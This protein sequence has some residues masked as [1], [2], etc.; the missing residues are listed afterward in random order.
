[1]FQ[2]EDGDPSQE[3]E[4]LSPAM[5]QAIA[6]VRAN[7]SDAGAWDKLDDVNAEEQRPEAVAWLFLQLLAGPDV[8]ATHAEAIGKRAI[9]FF[10]EWFEDPTAI[11]PTLTRVMELAPNADWAFHRLT[12]AYTHAKRWD[13]LL[14][15]YDHALVKASTPARRGELLDEAAQLA[16]DFAGDSDRATQYYEQLILLRP[17]DSQLAAALER[18]LERQSRYAELIALWT[19]RL[20]VLSPDEAR[21]T[22]LRMAGCFLEQLNQPEECLSVL[23]TTLVDAPTDPAACAMV[24]RVL[25]TASIKI[26]VRRQARSILLKSY[27]AE[28]HPDQRADVLTR[29]KSFIDDGEKSDALRELS[30]L[31]EQ[32]GRT[33]EAIDCC[34][35]LVVFDPEDDSAR[36]RL[37]TLTSSVSVESIYARTLSEAAMVLDDKSPLRAGALRTEAASVFA[38][39]LND[40]ESAAPLFEQVLASTNAS[41]EDQRLA[42]R[43]LDE[44][45]S[46][47]EFREPLLGTLERR[48][49]LESDVVEKCQVLER[50]ARLAQELNAVDRALAAWESIL[51]IDPKHA[52]GLD[53]TVALL[54][55][56]G[57]WLELVHALR[58]RA[59]ASADAQAVRADLVHAAQT[60]SHELEAHS[61]AVALW[62]EIG[63]RFG[64][65][66]Q[67]VD[68]LAALHAKLA[69]W[70]A[71]AQLLTS[72]LDD[73]TVT[74][75][76]AALNTQLGDVL[77]VHLKQPQQALSRFAA[78][79][80]MMPRHQD[81]IARLQE[82][83]EV[84]STASGAVD[85]LAG[86]YAAVDHW[87]G[88]LSLVDARIRHAPD[89]T[90]R[91]LVLLE[92]AST[93][94][95]RAADLAGAL[96]S[97]CAAF[98]QVPSESD[99]EQHMLRLGEATGDYQSVA[100]A[101]RAAIETA[102][103]Q[104]DSMRRK[105]AEIL[106]HRVKN[107]GDALN[108][109]R[110]LFSADQSDLIASEGCIRVAALTADWGI[111][112]A[113][114]VTVASAS[115]AIDSLL[116]VFESSAAAQN[117]WDI[118]AESLE[119]SLDLSG[120]T[121]QIGH[122]LWATLAG[123]HRDHR[124]NDDA[125]QTAFARAVACSPDD[126]ATL[127]ALAALQRRA[128][129]AA[130][131]D[132]L[133]LL[134]ERNSSV[135]ES[136]REAAGVAVGAA[137]DP[138][139]RLIVERLY[140]VA[141]GAWV[142]GDETASAQ[143]E[144]AT[145]QLV[146]LYSDAG[147][148]ARAVA[149]LE[150]AAKLPFEPTKSREYRRRAGAIAESPLNDSARALA[151]F[152]GVYAEDPD[153]N[154]AAVH[155]AQLYERRG[156]LDALLQLRSTQKQ[157]TVDPEV[158]S[159]IRIE[160]AR[161]RSML[162]DLTGA[163]AEYRE[164]L[165][166]LPGHSESI[167]LLAE[168]LEARS[169]FSE[170][171]DLYAEQGARLEAS[172][173]GVKA[174]RLWASAARLAEHTLHDDA[175]AIAAYT[176][177]VELGAT[178]ES[179]DSLAELHAKR[180]EHAQTVR[181]LEQ[182]LRLTDESARVGV[183]ARLTRAYVA[184]NKHSEASA[185]LEAQ[186]ERT[187]A[188][189]ELRALLA[190]RYR[191]AGKW[192]SLAD[193]LQASVEFA[194]DDEQRVAM[195]REAADV[196][197]RRLAQPQR[198]VPLLERA[199][200]LSPA[201]R[202]VRVALADARC[203]YG[204]YDGAR[205]ILE[206]LLT[207]Y[208]RRRPPERAK[209][210]RTLARIS[211]SQGH[212][213]DALEQLELA[214]NIDLD[215]PHTLQ[216]VGEVG[217]ELGELDRAATA[218]RSLLLLVR[219]QQPS[220]DIA[221]QSEVLFFLHRVAKAQ[222]QVDRASEVL[223]TAFEASRETPAEA[224]RF[225]QALRSAGEFELLF[226]ALTDRAS[227]TTDEDEQRALQSELAD[228]L[229]NLGRDSEALDL[230]IGAL[231]ASMHDDLAHG[232]TRR[233]ALKV[234]QP[235][236]Y[237]AA[238]QALATELHDSDPTDGAAGRLLLRAG[239]AAIDDLGDARLAVADLERA[240]EFGAPERDVLR[241]L[242]RAY[243][244]AEA[245]VPLRAVLMRRADSEGPED[246]LQERIDA[247]YRLAGLYLDDD[248]LRAEGLAT[249]DRALDQDARYDRA[250]KMLAKTCSQVADFAPGVQMYE[251]VARSLGDESVLL[252]AL[253]RTTA[254]PDATL[255]VF[256]E[257]VEIAQRVE[258][259]VRERRILERGDERFGQSADGVWLT[260]ALA[261]L[262]ATE[263]PR[264]AVELLQRA[265]TLADSSEALG[266]GIEAAQIA[267]GPLGDL[268]L[269]AASYEQLLERE[270][271]E[272][273][274][275]EPLLE[276]YR[277]LGEHQKLS[278]CI[279]RLI[280]NVYD[281][282]ERNRLRVERARILA[283]DPATRADAVAVLRSCL[284]DDPAAIEAANYL[285][286][287][288]EQSDNPSDLDEFLRWQLDSAKD[289]S[290]AVS[291]VALSLRLAARLGADRRE[292]V[293]ALYR[294]AL[295]WAPTDGEVL[296]G[297]LALYQSDGDVNERLE[298]LQK[299]LECTEGDEAALHAVALADLCQAREDQDGV[300][301][302][303]T[304][305]FHAAPAQQALRAR[306][307]QALRASGRDRELGEMLVF[308]ASHRTDVAQAVARLREAAG[309]Y[310]HALA[311]TAAVAATLAQAASLAPQDTQLALEYADALSA[312]GDHLAAAEAVKT[313][314]ELLG[315]NH[316]R[317]P[318]LR[319]ARAEHL[320]QSGLIADAV[321]ELELA[322]AR[323]PEGTNSL[324]FDAL[325]SL[326]S[327]A[328][329][330]GDR[331]LEREVTDRL[332]AVAT[333][334][335]DT[336]KAASVL[337]AWIE[338]D[339]SDIDAMRRLAT[340]HADAGRW[341]AVVT[342]YQKLVD[343]SSPEDK[344]DSVLR[345]AEACERA[346]RPGDAREGLEQIFHSQ[347]ENE[348]IRAWLRRVY[349][350]IDAHS[351]LA[352]LSLEDA[353]HAPAEAIRFDRL[354]QAGKLFV[355]AERHAD[356]LPPLEAAL[357]LRSGDHEATVALADAYIAL[358]NI[359]GATGLLQG[360][361]AALRNR[362]SPE[363]AAL[364]YRMARAAL[365]VGDQ[366]VQLAWLNAA[367]ESD[368]QNG[369]VASEL[370]ELA[371][372][373][374]D[375]E[376][377]MKALRALTLMKNPGPMTRAQAFYRQGV[378]AFRQG[379][380]R[381]AAFLAKRALSEDAE[382]ADAKDLL[383]QL[384]E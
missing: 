213:K 43:G 189:T 300:V 134:A 279:E 222:G 306:L 302:A 205:L 322:S 36:L 156:E 348:P 75:R 221:A 57:R 191:A 3:F 285:A 268:Q 63:T 207:E 142:A 53:A 293:I 250:A 305:G 253:D 89:A 206:Q 181:W 269:A 108:L 318:S 223:E 124:S 276:V 218:F 355:L 16:R 353:K 198:A 77:L 347:P 240:H 200:E 220:D 248:A 382:L 254:L 219:R 66:D 171:V 157:R 84:E 164:N 37:K 216:M 363:L 160:L 232:S 193:F 92:A 310:R 72:A 360:A 133:L 126:V 146:R 82:L 61:D 235:E 99:I 4:N 58:R 122:K 123:W 226:R 79:V 19:R 352:E 344:L 120:L 377:A 383:Q 159:E 178:V 192:A 93:Y 299:L 211:R 319:R 273:A 114:L 182:R 356:A 70:D 52:A 274:V 59:M 201:D 158:R 107:Y 161:V 110:E 105:C 384:G 145:E 74:E 292:D 153:D 23:A 296:R 217:W 364:Q 212:L 343:A 113:T 375:M 227:R 175:R 241:A 350:A 262:K 224:R 275:W 194:A 263:Q 264:Q 280:E 155:L 50:A 151:L 330:S 139:A 215:D 351:E 228:A 67:V 121:G 56:H 119:S 308:D 214:S 237:V 112:A 197:V 282:G 69:Q 325:E 102:A 85:A 68:A 2:G 25:D 315:V 176:Q 80:A 5:S 26:E 381:K 165:A 260:V 6:S 323:D 272:R 91:A 65:D 148:A 179:L 96:K 13:E 290:D 8:T 376:T 373:F 81:A 186:L 298:I 154:E 354:R 358:G 167:Q 324:L 337:E 238:V 28:S 231:R 111:G 342:V 73:A 94:E 118:A 187:P 242:D 341:D 173:D 150:A 258:D 313:A 199:A 7:P 277:Q 141:S 328:M 48:A 284:D 327:S 41:R 39:V 326:R 177:V 100:D 138:R 335:G 135:V 32:R 287:L 379:D 38:G 372:A 366:S 184:A 291:V 104:S 309:V 35:E 361:I 9:P 147:D 329:Q 188:E 137:G 247:A 378:I 183:V 117:A 22:R 11:A 166:E 17:A 87:E 95:T 64:R 297:L 131:I 196:F 24:D 314:I 267:A 365:A 340:L 368:H 130:L 362:R 115:G 103:P 203:A 143:V 46:R 144:W 256:R 251:R 60:L 172:G 86:A 162:D 289:R 230:R 295:D 101:Y 229:E 71:L 44:L 149:Q 334:M 244:K 109:Y 49:L 128:P 106:E 367:L 88:L 83:T 338:R 45:Y 316:A 311:D 208:G 336:A 303:L 132:T 371:M 209:V 21:T 210:H 307:E 331:T 370:A 346:G 33:P 169:G 140:A 1:M 380:P 15:L 98:V 195:L 190:E 345:L 78:T 236:R 127:H 333:Q 349:T 185:C 234:A 152:Q 312:N 332:S 51:Q 369:S 294:T 245:H 249:L 97:V 18:L 163:E 252:D 261:R 27:S 259:A 239:E 359:D 281:V 136:L 20:E 47:N 31:H 62:N 202:S 304:R 34:A 271:S 125:A 54:Q 116:S 225:E 374:D 29:S 12:L 129:D 243:V 320:Q 30:L 174:Q 233:L 339:P 266:Y 357:R 90:T 278:A 170:L 321:Q 204:D 76:R 180:S 55:N 270:P 246:S 286:D 283:A 10:Q 42:A 168:L 40:D 265:A 288:L 14:A 317:E 301:A 257:A 255:D